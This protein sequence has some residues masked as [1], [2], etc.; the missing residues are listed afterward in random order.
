M[1]SNTGNSDAF[2]RA[3]LGCGAMSERAADLEART[4]A[5]RRSR[6]QTQVKKAGVLDVS[7]KDFIVA[8]AREGG[9]KVPLVEVLEQFPSLKSGHQIKTLMPTARWPFDHALL[10]T[11][12]VP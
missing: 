2:T 12:V 8:W 4:V 1:D 5:K 10:V 11:Q 7:L 6:L 9:E 3:L